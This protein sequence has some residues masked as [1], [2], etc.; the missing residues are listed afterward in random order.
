MVLNIIGASSSFIPSSGGPP[1]PDTEWNPAD[2]SANVV[3]TNNNLTASVITIGDGGVRSLSSKTSGL[4][5][6]ELTWV[7]ASGGASGFGIA[8]AGATFT[9]AHDLA[10]DA[11][12]GCICYCTFGSGDIYY[13][14]ANASVGMGA[15][16]ANGDTGCLALD[17]THHTFWTRRNNGLWLNSGTADPATNTGGL[18]VPLFSSNPAFLAVCFSGSSLS[19]VTLNAGGTAYTFTPPAGFGAWA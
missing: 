1:P 19:Q 5:Y 15:G 17:M 9:G 6:V 10:A 13:N 2:K 14:G 3:L 16:L 18:S 7:N 11:T 8:T 4:Y 12:N